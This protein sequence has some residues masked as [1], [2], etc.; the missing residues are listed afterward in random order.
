MN[1][2]HSHKKGLDQGRTVIAVHQQLFWEHLGLAGALAVTVFVLLGL[3][4][5]LHD[6]TGPR[7]HIWAMVAF[8]S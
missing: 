4:L 1:S 6:V 2:W 8:S 3:L 5:R 7:V